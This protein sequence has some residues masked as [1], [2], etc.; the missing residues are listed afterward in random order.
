MKAIS[1]GA[2]GCE[3]FV[4]GDDEDQEAELR[5]IAKIIATTEPG[6]GSGLIFKRNGEIVREVRN[7]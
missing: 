5:R 7:G 1:Y 2:Y 6:N 4:I 3:S